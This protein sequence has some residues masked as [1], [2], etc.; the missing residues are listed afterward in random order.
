MA[1]RGR[2]ATGTIFKWFVNGVLLVLFTFQAFVA[3]CFMLRGHV[4]IPEVAL[5]H[6]I[7][8][9]QPFPEARMQVKEGRLKPDGGIWLG[10]I[11]LFQTNIRRPFLEAE[12]AVLHWGPSEDDNSSFGL[13]EFSVVNGA[14]HLPAV[15]APGGKRTPVLEKIALSGTAAGNRPRINAFAAM[16]ENIRL[17]GSIQWTDKKDALEPPEPLD[18]TSLPKLFE[19]LATGLKEKERFSFFD[20]P[21]LS[22]NLDFS[23]DTKTGLAARLFAPGIAHPEVSGT[24]FLAQAKLHLRDGSLRAKSPIKIFAQ[25]LNLAEHPV[26]A[27]ALR[28]HIAPDQWRRLFEKKG[29]KFEFAA[30]HLEIEG[31]DFENPLLTI[32]LDTLPKIEFQGSA[33]GL[34][35]AFGLAGAL[36]VEE[37]SGTVHANGSVD[38]FSML[39][40]AIADK[41]PPFHFAAPPYYNA[42]LEFDPDFALKSAKL[43]VRAHRVGVEDLVFDHIRARVSYQPGLLELDNALVQRAGEQV[44]MEFRLTPDNGNYSLWFAG[45]GAPD[46]YNPLLPDWWTAIF[47]PFSFPPES[48]SS[49][50]FLI[51]GNIREKVADR[52]FGR[53]EARDFTFKEVP[54]NKAG[55]IVRGKKRYIQIHPMRIRTPEGRV[56][57]R[58]A[59]TTRDDSLKA[60]MSVR[61]KLES[62]L[63]LDTARALLE[64]GITRHMRDIKTTRAPEVILEGVYF[65]DAYTEFRGRDYVKFSA[66][67]RGPLRY[68]NIPLDSLRFDFIGREENSHIRNLRFGF[69]GGDGTGAIDVLSE[70]EP[71]MR[72]EF[73][74]KKANQQEAFRLLNPV[75]SNGNNEP[76]KTEEAKGS[77][78][79]DPQFDLNL[80]LEGPPAGNIEEFFGYGDFT[81]KDENLASIKLLG[82]LSRVLGSLRLNFTTFDLNRMKANFKVL[83][84]RLEFAPIF[85]DG[86]ETSI[87]ATG[88]MG[89]LNQKL[90]MRVVVNLVGNVGEPDSYL[91]KFRNLFNRLPRLLEFKVSGTLENQKWRS[92]Y[93]PRNLLPGL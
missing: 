64:D 42:K 74:L 50:D 82:P 55:M 93:D 79:K 37:R 29:G 30:R 22:F 7:R 63:R 84:D 19:L 4:P 47:Q 32:Q 14:I 71:G 62:H 86:P 81:L 1:S 10:G 57:G 58:L 91:G 27:K 43:R 69:A 56:R 48:F 75:F 76:N 46:A 20:Q 15:Y 44:R 65:H 67:S 45:Y 72:L 77:E 85:I 25:E 73:N 60:P 24:N 38:L 21:T 51:H 11:E 9:L 34:H 92:L 49:A 5:N 40:H 80:R 35:G 87:E 17:R 26:T 68:K 59:F 31:R 66:D 23:S 36:D 16:H 2:T 12:A 41:L 53:A 61:Y 28:A 83:G 90:D 3:G 70:E 18:D 78:N 88:T 54:V 33:D 13:R 6:F 39:P 89:L 8:Q 52:F